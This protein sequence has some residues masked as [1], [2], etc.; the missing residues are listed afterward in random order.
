MTHQGQELGLG[1]GGQLNLLAIGGFGP[2]LMC[3]HSRRLNG[4]QHQGPALAQDPRHLHLH[5][6]DAADPQTDGYAK[7]LHS[8]PIRDG[9]QGRP[10]GHPRLFGEPVI[11]H[12]LL[13]LIGVAAGQ[14]METTV[15]GKQMPILIAQTHGEGR[16]LEERPRIGHGALERLRFAGERKLEFAQIGP[17]RS[18]RMARGGGLAQHQQQASGVGYIALW[19]LHG[20]D[21]K[22][23]PAALMQDLDIAHRMRLQRLRGG[24][25]PRVPRQFRLRIAFVATLT[26]EQGIDAPR[27]PGIHPRLL[28]QNR[29]GADVDQRPFAVAVAIAD[30]DTDRKVVEH[31]HQKREVILQLV[32]LGPHPTQGRGLRRTQVSREAGALA[33][34]QRTL[35]IRI[36]QPFAQGSE[37]GQRRIQ[38]EQVGR[39]RKQGDREHRE[40][41]RK[42]LPVRARKGGAQISGH[43]P[44]AGVRVPVATG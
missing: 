18:L 14:L 13:K 12:L 24:S 7:R 26:I 2:P 27:H 36:E 4:H 19:Q 29:F 41:M 38:P 21:L 9:L 16:Q 20:G 34:D 44:D 6:Q 10:V 40:R 39:E 31:L 30:R 22:R 5:R 23:D 25:R 8:A 15:A 28:T 42:A 1:T 33:G 3:V 35:A 32:G 43:H 37:R 11:R 17:Q